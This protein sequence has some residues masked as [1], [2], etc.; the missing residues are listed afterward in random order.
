MTTRR[1]DFTGISRLLNFLLRQVILD[2]S[3][4]NLAQN[5]NH[6]TLFF[7]RLCSGQAAANRTGSILHGVKRQR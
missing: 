2:W 6:A 7:M 4:F 5:L 3:I 1:D